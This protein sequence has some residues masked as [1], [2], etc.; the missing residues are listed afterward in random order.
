[1]RQIGIAAFV[2]LLA[3]IVVLPI[4]YSQ[5][6]EENTNGKI[7]S[8][9]GQ[10]NT[11]KPDDKN[12]G[13]QVEDFVH[14]AIAHFKQQRDETHD[15]I[16]DCREKMRNATDDTR[17]Q[18]KEEC[19]KQLQLIREKHQ[20]ERQHFQELFKEFKNHVKI[21]VAE[22]RGHHV[23]NETRSSAIAGINEIKHNEMMEKHNGMKHKEMQNRSGNP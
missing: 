22:A 19:H 12:V 7:N 18:I 5:A 3:S 6:A 15:A 17:S 11:I 1:M 4:G 16:K 8:F 10:N 13:Q 23:N 14:Q 2:I 21:L 9:A 20:Q